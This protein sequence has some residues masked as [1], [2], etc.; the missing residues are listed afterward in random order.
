[1]TDGREGA[2]G[3]TQRGDEEA[4]AELKPLGEQPHEQR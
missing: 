3:R 4:G 1:M 2:E